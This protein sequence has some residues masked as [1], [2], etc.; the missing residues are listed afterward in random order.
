MVRCD[1][2]IPSGLGGGVS[3]VACGLGITL[4]LLGNVLG[5]RKREGQRKR[6]ML[7]H[8]AR[9]AQLQLNGSAIEAHTHN[10]P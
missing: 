10:P 6:G 2:R 5:L 3:L 1:V 7:S 9:L 4:R 8:D